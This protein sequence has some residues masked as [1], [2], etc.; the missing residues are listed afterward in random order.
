M[1]PYRQLRRRSVTPRGNTLQALT[2]SRQE[3]F[4]PAL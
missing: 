3:R 4:R 1:D 2:N